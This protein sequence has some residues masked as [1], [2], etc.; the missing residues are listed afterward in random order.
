M[1]VET[2]T[3]CGGELLHGY[4]FYGGGLGAYTECL[5]CGDFQKTLD[6]D[7]D[8]EDAPAES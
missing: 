4:G 1:S 5:R 7:E 3:K 8:G 6:S 2:C